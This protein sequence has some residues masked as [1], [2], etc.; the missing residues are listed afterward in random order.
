MTSEEWWAV[1]AQR[2]QSP[3]Q[4]VGEKVERRPHMPH[5]GRGAQE[6]EG[7]DRTRAKLRGSGQDGGGGKRCDRETGGL[8]Q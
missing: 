8:L 5:S 1:Q 4:R 2:G 3:W 6:Q 7:P